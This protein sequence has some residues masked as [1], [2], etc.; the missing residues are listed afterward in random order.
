MW[1]F[2]TS[3]GQ[4]CAQAAI[5]FNQ[6]LLARLHC[7]LHLGLAN[8]AGLHG[9]LQ[10]GELIGRFLQGLGA[11]G[12]GFARLGQRLFAEVGC[13]QPLAELGERLFGS[14]A[15]KLQHFGVLPVFGSKRA[16]CANLSDQFSP[17]GLAAGDLLRC[18]VVLDLPFLLSSL[19]GCLISPG[20]L[21]FLDQGFERRLFLFQGRFGGR[22]VKRLIGADGRMVG[23]TAERAG[24]IRLQLLAM[25]LQALDAL[26][27]LQ[28]FLLVGHLRFELAMLLAE[29]DQGFFAGIDLALALLQLRGLRRLLGGQF[30]PTAGKGIELLPTVRSGLFGLP[31]LTQ[32]GQR[33]TGEA[34]L[35]LGVGS[36]QPSLGFRFCLFFG[37]DRGGLRR[38]LASEFKLRLLKLLRHHVLRGDVLLEF[39][40][41]LK[42]LTPDAESLAERGTL[43]MGEAERV[44][45]LAFALGELQLLVGLLGD[46][47]GEGACVVMLLALFELLPGPFTVN[48][49]DLAFGLLAGC[50]GLLQCLVQRLQDFGGFAGCKALELRGGSLERGM[51]LGQLRFSSVCFLLAL[52]EVDPPL[53]LYLHEIVQM[54]NFRQLPVEVAGLQLHLGARFTG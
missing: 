32:F 28:E 1:H 29:G 44:D 6:F 50:F 8:L 9:L 22:N 45:L 7:Q 38:E 25:G 33:L 54:L 35:L 49:S 27:L 40:A 23:R 18:F 47:G 42:L 34:L 46:A 4:R 26:F 51:G 36:L 12:G 21:A 20:L 3:F 10:Q 53:A 48:F 15:A 5:E 31:V 37:V 11:I 19:A 52:A 2:K 24:F 14:N 41:L 39:V 30:A 16:C 13:F 17:F 43:R